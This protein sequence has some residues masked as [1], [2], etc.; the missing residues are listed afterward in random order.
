MFHLFVPSFADVTLA[1]A[2]GAGEFHKSQ[3][4]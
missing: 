1:R 2:G 4:F 3:Y